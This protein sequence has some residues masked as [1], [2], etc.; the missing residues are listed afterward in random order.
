MK[1]LGSASHL[2]VAYV[3]EGSRRI[4]NM[5]AEHF[6]IFVQER[7]DGTPRG[8]IGRLAFPAYH[9]AGILRG[10][11]VSF[12]RNCISRSD[13]NSRDMWVPIYYPLRGA[14][15]KRHIAGG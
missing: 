6:R 10:W 13:E 12:D 2:L 7:N 1:V 5:L 3:N 15:S 4:E 14:G 11:S 8:I 9:E